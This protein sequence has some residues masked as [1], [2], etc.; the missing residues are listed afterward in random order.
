MPR[1]ERLLDPTAGPLE[2][3]AHDLRT[4]RKRAG[5]P[6][7]R[8]MAKRAHYSVATLA[9]AARGL[10]KPSL[11]VTLAYV[12]ACGGDVEVWSRRWHS[13]SGELEAL[14]ARRPGR[15]GGVERE[16]PRSPRPRPAHGPRQPGPER[17]HDH[18]GDRVPDPGAGRAQRP[19]RPTG[20]GPAQ[21]PGRAPGPDPVQRPDRA[22]GA[23]RGPDRTPDHALAPDR[24]P[25]WHRARG[26]G[27]D[28]GHGTAGPA[29][30]PSRA[31]ARDPATDELT[32]EERAELSRLR[33]EVEELRRANEV[34]KAA[35]AIFAADLRTTS[36]VVYN[37][38]DR[39]DRSA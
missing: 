15:P 22:E 16:P 17:H 37:P 36:K 18:D 9:E 20:R 5:N 30:P 7:Y 32:G 28:S 26:G 11:K 6:S 31:S 21:R 12:T 27:R 1:P 34:L 39:Q 14:G 38:A 8:T 29:D 3:F 10:H 24:D 35:S 33:G 2:A 25:G 4:L 13:V 23:D 19:G